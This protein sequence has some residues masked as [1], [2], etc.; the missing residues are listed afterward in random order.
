MFGKKLLKN[1]VTI[2][3]KVLHTKNE[4]IYSALDS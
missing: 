2:A 4:K 1:N 3:L